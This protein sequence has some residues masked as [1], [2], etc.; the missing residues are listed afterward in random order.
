MKIIGAAYLLY[1]AYAIWRDARTPL[2]AAQN[3]SGL[4][5]PFIRG[6]LVNASNPKSVLFASAVLVVI[7]PRDLALSEKMLIM[8]NQMLVEWTAYAAFALLLSTGKARDRYLRPETCFRP[9]RRCGAWCTRTAVDAGPLKRIEGTDLM[10]DRLPHE[11]GFHVSWDQLH[12]D[13]RAL[14]VA[15]GWART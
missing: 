13:A 9:R 6:V 15:A 7:F 1:L 14:A 4:R 5:H 3:T 8:M 10:T 11:K 2:E 12:R